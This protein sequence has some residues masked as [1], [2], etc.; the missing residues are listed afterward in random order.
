M[1]PV[2]A[3][4]GSQSSLDY[5]IDQEIARL[6]EQIELLKSLKGSGPETATVMERVQ[7]VFGERGVIW[8]IRPNQV[9]QDIPLALIRQGNMDRVLRLLVQIEHG[10]HP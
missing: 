5:T 10:I 9:L 1:L 8:L 4:P 3:N 7:E 2:E 6:E